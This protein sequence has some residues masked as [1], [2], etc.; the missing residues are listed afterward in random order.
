MTCHMLNKE[1]IKAI[2]PHREPFLLVDEITELEVGKRAVG[3]KFVSPDA[4]WFQ[5]H[6]PEMPVMPGVL[7]LEAMAQTGAV[8]ALS[9]PEMKGKIAVF[10]S[11]N[12]VKFKRMVVPGDTLRMEVEM[13]KMRRMAGS[14]VGKAYVGDEL[15]CSAEFMFIIPKQEG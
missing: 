4:F 5:G 7:I 1:E 2:I 9:L 12:N 14:G 8:A 3:I 10:G 6:F 13:V 11:A 15:A